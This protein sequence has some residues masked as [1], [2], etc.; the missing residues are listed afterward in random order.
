MGENIR[1]CA[2]RLLAM[3]EIRGLTEE[4]M[5]SKTG[6]ALEEY[7][8]LEKGEKDFQLSFLLAAANALKIDLY[9]LITGE[10][11]KLDFCAVTRKG[12]GLS[13]HRREAYS[14]RHL[15]YNFK[16]RK[17]EPFMVTVKNGV[18]AGSR[19]ASS[20]ESQEFVYIVKGTIEL[21]IDGISEILYEGDSAYFDS[22]KEH[23]F[24]AYNCD[25]AQFIT[26]V[27]K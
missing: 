22:T 21:I 1:Q 19:A 2:Q 13:I 12:K 7:R 24:Y 9:E 23:V 20:H 4:E 5:A 11:S 16:N 15:A 6:V 10:A 18:P 8:L 17:A 25:D 26:L 14:Y 27:I 3:R